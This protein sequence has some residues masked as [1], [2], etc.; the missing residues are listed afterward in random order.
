MNYKIPTAFD[1]GF[2][3]VPYGMPKF[4]KRCILKIANFLEGMGSSRAAHHLEIQGFFKEAEHV[5]AT[6]SKSAQARNRL[7][8]RL[9]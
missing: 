9:Q 6:H 5:R 7:I 8:K 3:H 2:E 4:F 1:F